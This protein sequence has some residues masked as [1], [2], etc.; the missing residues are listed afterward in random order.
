VLVVMILSIRLLTNG[1]VR[2]R[3]GKGAHE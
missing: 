3:R 2:L 1:Y